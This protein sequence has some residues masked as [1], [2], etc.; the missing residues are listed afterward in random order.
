MNRAE[1]NILTWEIAPEA[2]LGSDHPLCSGFTEDGNGAFGLLSESCQSTAKLT[3]YSI[4]FVVGQPSIRPQ[5]QLE[6]ETVYIIYVLY[7][8]KHIVM[9]ILTFLN[10]FPLG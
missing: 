4:Q 5:D 10:T 8:Y 6:R 3:D 9:G 1:W 2:C 7:Y